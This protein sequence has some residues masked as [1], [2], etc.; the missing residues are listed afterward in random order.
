MTRTN[1]EP[2]RPAAELVVSRNREEA[3]KAMTP[4]LLELAERV[5]CENP[6]PGQIPTILVFAPGLMLM[7]MR[8]PSMPGATYVDVRVASNEPDT[9]GWGP[10]VFSAWFNCPPTFRGK[11]A[12]GDVHVM[13]WKRGWEGA[14]VEVRRAPQ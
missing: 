13:S 11:Y 2:F 5:V 8:T 14:L 12:N 3:L 6:K 7:A 9:L 10:K 1:V 4:R